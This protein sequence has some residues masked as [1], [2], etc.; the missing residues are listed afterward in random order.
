MGLSFEMLQHQ[1]IFKIFLLFKD[2]RRAFLLCLIMLP[3]CGCNFA[4]FNSF[5]VFVQFINGL[6]TMYMTLPT[7]LI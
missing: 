1:T 6:S 2:C 3:I 7:V 4:D 5:C